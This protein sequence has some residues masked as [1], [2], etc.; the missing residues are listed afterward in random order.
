MDRLNRM[1]QAAQGM[2]M[3]GAAPGGVS[4]PFASFA[5]CTSVTCGRLFK[6]FPRPSVTVDVEHGWDQVTDKDYC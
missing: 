4:R 1:L 6:V 5:L 2:G 3:G